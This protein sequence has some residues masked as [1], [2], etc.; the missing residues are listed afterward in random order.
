[1]P[2]LNRTGPTGAGPMT[3]RQMGLCNENNRNAPR[4][5]DGGYGFGGGRGAGRG[6]RGGFNRG[7]G[8]GGGRGFGFRRGN[9]FGRS[10]VDYIPDTPDEKMLE[11]EVSYLKEQLSLTEKELE[12]LRKQKNE[13]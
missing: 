1:M 12:K 3:G 13:E 7:T 8:R 5:G 2:G 6:F 9:P 4:G 10:P 11:N